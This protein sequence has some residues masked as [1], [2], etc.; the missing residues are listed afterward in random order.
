MIVNEIFYSIMGEANPYG[1]GVPATFVRFHGCT[2]SC[3][4][5]SLG[6]HCDTPNS[7]ISTEGTEI[8]TPKKL[9]NKILKEY[10]IPALLCI[11]GGEP[12][13]QPMIPLAQFIQQVRRHFFI[14]LETSGLSE[15]SGIEDIVHSMVVDIKLPSTGRYEDNILLKDGEIKKLGI[16]DYVK[17]VVYDEHDFQVAKDSIHRLVYRGANTNFVIGLHSDSAFSYQ[18]LMDKMLEDELLGVCSVN[19]QAHKLLKLR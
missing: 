11:T 16:K 1:I 18:Q 6:R 5:S 8:Y 17:F 14:V 2:H 19:F 13:Q 10:N 3:Y 7:F 9:A 12:L 4:L 15:F